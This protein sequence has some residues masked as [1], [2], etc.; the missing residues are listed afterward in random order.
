M[1][2]IISVLAYLIL[3]IGIGVYASTRVKN[4][5]DYMLAGKRLPV[6]LATTAIFATWFGSETIMGASSTF[7]KSGLYGVIED[8]FGAFLCLF[9][10]GT[11]FAKKIY[12]LNIITVSDLFKRRYG[13]SVEIISAIMMLL[14]FF[15]WIA[16]QFIGLGILVHVL[17]GINLVAS[18]VICMSI[19]AIYTVF[20]G[21]WSVAITD[22]VQSIVIVFG[23]VLLAVQLHTNVAPVTQVFANAPD[24]WFKFFPERDFNEWMFYIAAWI[25]LGLGSIPSQDI[26]QRVLSSKSADVAKKSSILGACMYLFFGLIPLLAAM[27]AR[28]FLDIEAIGDTQLLLPRLV[29]TY[30]TP[31]VQ[32]IFMGALISAILSTASGVILA[33]ATI[34]SENIIKPIKTD[35]NE[36]QFLI[37]LRLSVVGVSVISLLM[38][39][40]KGNIFELVADASTLGLIALFVPLIGALWI[41]KST[42]LGC[43]LAMLFGV[44]MWFFYDDEA[45]NFPIQIAGLLLSIFGMLL[46]SAIQRFKNS[47]G[48]VLLDET[49]EITSQA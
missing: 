37:S 11:V 15:G 35:I 38:A 31:F 14:T 41:K 48:S 22:F 42:T 21:M 6:S 34:I 9:L 39:I 47:N 17:F 23:L 2:L 4:S 26:F 29:L 13:T 19:V 8:P 28:Q 40:S 10:V 20:G 46:G 30:A 5:S 16:G 12:K 7:A 33:C 45:F 36:T 49:V 24:G 32:I 18:I 3:S 27:Y 43:I 44:L 25:T 1:L